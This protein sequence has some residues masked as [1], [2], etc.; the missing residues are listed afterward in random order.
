MTGDAHRASVPRVSGD[1]L[2]EGVLFDAGLTL[3][4]ERTAARDVA[5]EVLEGLAVPFEPDALER[6]MAVSMGQIAAQWHYGDW[7]LSESSV[8]RLFTAGYREGLK[9]L[10]VLASDD[11]E[12][13]RV[14][15]AIHDAYVDARHWRAYDDVAP[16]L[17]ALWR[18]G[19]PMGV[20]SDWGHGLEAILLELEL[21]RYFEFVLVSARIGFGKPDPT[22]FNLARARLG[23]RAERTVYVGDTYVKDVFGARAGGLVPILLD[24]RG[25]LPAMDCVVV[26][27][28]L[29][30]ASVLGAVPPDPPGAGRIRSRPSPVQHAR[31][32]VAAHAQDRPLIPPSPGAH[33]RRSP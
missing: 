5:A 25:G 4:H 32:P 7:W 6:A 9:L 31:R 16:A 30:A 33:G 22:V 27:D 28:L 19:V 2:L 12:R 10:P 21:G 23:A 24:R 3:I 14:A 8:R 20:V 29:E 26:R 1:P 13:V 18:A 17:D 11:A 15:A